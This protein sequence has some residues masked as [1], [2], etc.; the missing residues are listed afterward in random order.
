MTELLKDKTI[1]LGVTGSISAYKACEVVRLFIKAGA[2]V[3]VVMTQSATRFISP[4]T[5]E[6]LTRDKVLYEESESWATRLNHI[7][8]GKDCDVFVV[9]PAT[10]NTINKLSK[11]IADNILTQTALAF[12]KP[13]L[14]APSANTNMINNHLT[15]N[16]LKMLAVNDITIINSQNKLLACGDE[17]EGGLPEPLEIFYQTAK[18]LLSEDFWRD[19]RVV[20]TGGG[21]REKIDDVRFVSNFSSGKMA[22]A[23]SLALYLKGADVCLITTKETKELP[24]DIY[25]IDVEDANEMLEFTIDSIRIAKKGKMSKTSLNHLEAPH[26]ILKQPFLFMASAVADFTP[27]YPQVG[28]LKKS[29]IGE[30]WSIE[31][32]QT[33]DILS[34]VDKNNLITIGFKAEMDINNGLNNATNA[35][36]TKNIDA[37]CYNHLED[38]QSFGTSTNE[39]TFIT[40]DKQIKFNRADKL[41]IAFNILNESRQIIK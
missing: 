31:M 34:C 38:S 20:V 11:G 22:N 37:I 12:N 9:A 13:I 3:K 25:T 35:L 4:L 6:A 19:R 14:I 2:K 1:L 7:E 21:T 27:S 36:L 40:K 29:D 32:K 10:A 24:K 39:V 16:S 15:K 8:I 26:L 17:G 33:K 41:E 18:A 5:F 30:K 28:K 23:L